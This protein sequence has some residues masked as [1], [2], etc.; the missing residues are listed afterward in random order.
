M[1]EDNSLLLFADGFSYFHF[2]YFPL[3]I[4]TIIFHLYGYSLCVSVVCRGRAF[5]VQLI[6]WHKTKYDSS[7]NE[8]LEAA[9]FSFFVLF[10]FGSVEIMMIIKRTSSFKWSVNDIGE[11]QLT[12]LKISK[13]QKLY[14]FLCMKIWQRTIQNNNNK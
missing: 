1:D 12:Q 7:I 14:T 8:Q 13:T 10:C 3:M 6:K 2:L 11:R 5:N 4:Y 9:W